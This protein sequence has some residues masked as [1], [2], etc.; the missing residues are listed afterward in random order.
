MLSELSR[1]RVSYA[2]LPLDG[3][4]W[5]RM[6]WCTVGDRSEHAK[7]RER[8][9]SQ[10]PAVTS[11]GCLRALLLVDRELSFLQIT[12]EKNR[13][14]F[15][16]DFFVSWRVAA[17][18]EHHLCSAEAA[19]SCSPCPVEMTCLW[20]RGVIPAKKTPNSY[21][22]YQHL[23]TFPLGMRTTCPPCWMDLS[24]GRLHRREAGRRGCKTRP[25]RA[26]RPI[27]ILTADGGQKKPRREA[28]SLQPSSLSLC[29]LLTQQ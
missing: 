2:G 20:A 14:A 16:I 27:G 23:R 17:P 11:A 22:V 7:G 6:E 1:L 8:E 12:W 28:Q 9:S 19:A 15:S 25:V 24:D 26:Q 3:D 4:W 10:R 29:S 13:I 18:A 21:H 5:C